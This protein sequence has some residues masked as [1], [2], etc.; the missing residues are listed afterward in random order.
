MEEAE[1][2]PE[3]ILPQLPVSVFTAISRESKAVQTASI[4]GVNS[5][6]CYVFQ[7]LW[8]ISKLPWNNSCWGGLESP[9]WIS[10]SQ[11]LTKA[12]KNGTGKL[13]FIK[14][15]YES[16]E[17]FFFL[18]NEGQDVDS[19]SEF[20]GLEAETQRHFPLQLLHGEV[21]PL[22]RNSLTFRSVLVTLVRTAHWQLDGR[23]SHIWGCAAA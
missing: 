15:S 2:P 20:W 16:R 10:G 1:E 19:H 13:C 7:T 21:Y 14:G 9:W 6:G 3:W 12:L 17:F 23:E 11:T 4:S 18:R 22:R 5:Y 8:Q